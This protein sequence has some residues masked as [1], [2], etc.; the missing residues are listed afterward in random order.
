M[1][2]ARG[3]RFEDDSWKQVGLVNFEFGQS[4]DVILVV[5]LHFGQPRPAKWFL[6]DV[7]RLARQGDPNDKAELPLA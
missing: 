4:M 7:K 5:V 1:G 3:R 2:R 6:L